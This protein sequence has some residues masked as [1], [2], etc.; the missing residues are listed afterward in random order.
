MRELLAEGS[1]LRR[2]VVPREKLSHNAA[3]AAVAALTDVCHVD[4]AVPA[5]STSSRATLPTQ[6]SFRRDPES[7]VA[8]GARLIVVPIAPLARS[9]SDHGMRIMVVHP[10][11]ECS[12]PRW[13]DTGTERRP[14]SR[15]PIR[16]ISFF[17]ETSNRGWVCRKFDSG[18]VGRRGQVSPSEPS[19]ELI[20]PNRVNWTVR[21]RFTSQRKHTRLGPWRVPG[22]LARSR[23]W[24]IRPPRFLRRSVSSHGG[25]MLVAPPA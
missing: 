9:G 19:E 25:K 22:L 7:V 14:R 2:P 6:E 4:G 13:T 1:V 20:S 18:R 8:S 3:P 17:N 15:V 16:A 5:I 12:L 24:L 10:E 21:C 11:A 23:A